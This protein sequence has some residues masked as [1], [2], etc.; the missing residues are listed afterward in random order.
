M[1]STK[2]YCATKND[3]NSPPTGNTQGQKPH[4]F[5][6]TF[7]SLPKWLCTE[8]IAAKINPIHAKKVLYLFTKEFPLFVAIINIVDFQQSLKSYY[9]FYLGGRKVSIDLM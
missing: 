2:Q 6:E 5:T 4:Y 9:C 3:T 7:L 1:Y 8:I